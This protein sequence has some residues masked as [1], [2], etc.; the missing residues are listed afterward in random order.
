MKYGREMTQWAKCL[1]NKPDN[2]ECESL[3]PTERRHRT[4]AS[5][6]TST[7]EAETGDFSE[8]FEP[9]C[10]AYVPRTTKRNPVSHMTESKNQHL[11]LFSDFHTHVVCLHTNEDAH[12]HIIH[13][14]SHHT[15]N[16]KKRQR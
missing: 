12:T 7:Q 8:A 5:P 10:L 16:E 9:A 15:H 3:K 11:R 2:L 1:L 6:V 14:N 4:P 13:I